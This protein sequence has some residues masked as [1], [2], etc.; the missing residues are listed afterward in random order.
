MVIDLKNELSKRRLKSRQSLVDELKE[1]RDQLADVI[2]RL[3]PD[4]ADRIAECDTLHEELQ[5]LVLDPDEAS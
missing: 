2:V 1:A 5:L 3:Y 4:H